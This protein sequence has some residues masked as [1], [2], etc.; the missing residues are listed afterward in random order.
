MNSN[1]WTEIDTCYLCGEKGVRTLGGLRDI[2]F[3]VNGEWSLCRCSNNGCG[4]VWTTPRPDSE[5]IGSLYEDFLTHHHEAFNFIGD[6]IKV[7]VKKRLLEKRC[8]Y[9]FNQSYPVLVKIL[10]AIASKSDYLSAGVLGSV[11]NLQGHETG[12]LL[13]VGCGN[14]NFIYEMKSLGWDVYGVEPDHQS[15]EIAANKY[16]LKVFCGSL[17]SAIFEEQRFDVITLNH[18]VEHL[19]DPVSVLR[20]CLDLLK[21]DGKVVLT[22]PNIDSHGFEKYKKSWYALD[23]PRHFFQFSLQTLSECAMKAGFKRVEGKTLFRSSKFID[24]ASRQIELNSRMPG[25]RPVSINK[26]ES[27]KGYLFSLKEYICVKYLNK[28]N[29]GEEIFLELYK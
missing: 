8:G 24:I 21:D 28:K 11:M 13:D 7:K 23:I 29:A 2:Y 27:F 5:K 14:G 10:A 16:K 6:S 22:A 3:N 26:Y 19:E 17:E 25:A 12:S 9:T 1:S 4:L 20:H 18:V 15:A